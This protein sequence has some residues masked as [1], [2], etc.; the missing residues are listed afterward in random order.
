[1]WFGKSA[2]KK[3]DPLRQY[4]CSGNIKSSLCIAAKKLTN[5]KIEIEKKKTNRRNG[6]ETIK[7]T[8][9]QKDRRVKK[10]SI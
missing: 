5:G 9:K 7:Q 10:T 8:N 3:P 2:T 1:M 6:Y 4:L